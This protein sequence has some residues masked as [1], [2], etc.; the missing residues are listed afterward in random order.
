MKKIATSII[1][2]LLTSIVTTTAQTQGICSMGE[3]AISELP[4]D[5]R[6]EKQLVVIDKWGDTI[7][8]QRTYDGK[9]IF[10]ILKSK[11]NTFYIVK[12]D[13]TADTAV[14]GAHYPERLDDIAW[15]NNLA[16]YRAYGPALQWSG[17]RAFGYDVW[18]KREPRPIVK[19]RYFNHL[20]KNISYHTDH[21]NGMD[22]YA[23]GASLGC[24]TAALYIDSTIIYP[25]CWSEYRILDNG[26][27]R[28]TVEL[29]YTP[30][31]INGESVTEVRT[32]T[33]DYGT[34]LNKTAI[35]FEGLKEKREIV[36]GIVIHS[37]NP[38]GYYFDKQGV[39]TVEDS[40]QSR[41]NGAIYVGLIKSEGFENC[42]FEP[43]KRGGEIAGHI[44]G[45]G[46]IA[47]NEEYIYYWGA[48]WSKNGITK[49][50]WHKY[51]TDEYHR[52]IGNKRI[53]IKTKQ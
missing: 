21:G 15:E 27:W 7:V 20:H 6:N 23:V 40:T 33:L 37:S 12:S 50:M 29:R 9:V 51:I 46:A 34:Y 19:E 10:P 16:A 44:L 1:I 17:E 39:I 52:T 3:V 26:P 38:N 30:T 25:Y 2:T 18:T 22:V 48:G 31:E 11:S 14:C 36:A 5:L 41:G 47:P 42:H 35:R 32:I 43:Y 13:K 28:F 45:T 53:R 49:E 8:T 4:L 24:G